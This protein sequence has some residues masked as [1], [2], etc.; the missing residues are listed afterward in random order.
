MSDSH[1]VTA[2]GRE[3]ELRGCTS[4]THIS[5]NKNKVETFNMRKGCFVVGVFVCLF[6]LKLIFRPR[7]QH[8]KS[9]FQKVVLV[10]VDF[11]ANGANHT[12]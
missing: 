11:F 4:I 9:S 10:C 7:L 5:I 3:T 8:L 6:V 1:N 2:L 12:G